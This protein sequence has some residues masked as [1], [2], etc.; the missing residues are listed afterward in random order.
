MRD[1]AKGKPAEILVR[2]IDA[3]REMGSP[4]LQPTTSCERSTRITDRSMHLTEP[5]K[6]CMGNA[7]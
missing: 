7:R 1:E 4:P 3:V 2:E 6:P 5:K